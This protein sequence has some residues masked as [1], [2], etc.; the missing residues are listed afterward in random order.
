MKKEKLRER[1]TFLQETRL[2]TLILF[3]AFMVPALAEEIIFLDST[4][5]T[6]RID[7]KSPGR[8]ALPAPETPRSWLKSGNTTWN[9]TYQDVVSHTGQGFDDPSKGAARRLVVARVLTYLNDVLNASPPAS[10]DIVFDVSETDGSGYLASAGSYF[11]STPQFTNGF[12]FE[13]ITTGTDPAPSMPDIFCTVDFGYAWYTGTENPAPSEIDFFSVMLHEMTHGLGFLSLANPDGSSMIASGVY[14]RFDD[15]L[16]TGS[17]IDLFS[18]NGSTVIFNGNSLSLLGGQGGVYFRGTNATTTYG[19]FPPIYAPSS[20][21]PG[22]SISHWDP[23]IVGGGV[24]VPAIYYGATNRM[25]AAVEY[26]ALRDLGFTQTSEP[27]PVVPLADFS[28]ASYSVSEDAGF[29]TITVILSVAPGPGNTASVSYA[30]SG[31]SATAGSDFVATSGLLTFSETETSK[32]FTVQILEDGAIESDETVQLTLSSP[33]GCLLANGNNP[34]ILTILDND[35]DSD[36]DGI[37]D[38]DEIYYDNDPSYNP[39]HPINNPSGTD[40]D[41]TNPDSD[42]DGYSDGDER[43]E[44][45]DPLNPN[46]HPNLALNTLPIPLFRDTPTGPSREPFSLRPQNES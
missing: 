22:S 19:S 31:G 45:T 4:G 41:Y 34:A 12:C 40:L 15:Y 10:I 43:N 13:H 16:Y 3:L 5:Q 37:S 21:Q 28:S 23:N 7:S 33:S 14:S 35:I 30:T 39:Y 1:P 9:I 42:G 6:E 20:W 27:Q 38:Y 44:G 36:G 25:Y 32:S 2:Y 17:G 11:W 46:S 24:M 8:H 29:A 18:W 26:S